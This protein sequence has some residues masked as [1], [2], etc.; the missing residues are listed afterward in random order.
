MYINAAPLQLHNMES[1]KVK[2]TSGGKIVPHSDLR[3]G[4]AL[5]DLKNKLKVLFWNT[6][7]SS[8]KEF[9]KFMNVH[10]SILLGIRG[11][12][13]HKRIKAW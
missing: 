5:E 10:P 4:T 7:K 13:L 3:E 2:F 11:I 8:I 6:K 9:R 12:D 1:S